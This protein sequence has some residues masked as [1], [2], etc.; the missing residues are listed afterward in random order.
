MPQA[1][2]VLGVV[3]V[4]ATSIIHMLSTSAVSAA[5]AASFLLVTF[6]GL[7]P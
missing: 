2:V 6:G 4:V 7:G 3:L 5:S 1:V